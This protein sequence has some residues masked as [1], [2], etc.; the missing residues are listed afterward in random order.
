MMASI[1]EE[2]RK[3]WGDQASGLLEERIDLEAILERTM[4]SQQRMGAAAARAI[5]ILER[6]SPET[7]GILVAEGCIPEAV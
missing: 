2:A 3:Q 1:E 5:R 7:R 6:P 4:E